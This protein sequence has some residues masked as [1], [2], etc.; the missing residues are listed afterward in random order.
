[1]KESKQEK[2][3]VT[4]CIFMFDL[5]FMRYGYFNIKITI[6]T[7]FLL[8]QQNLQVVVHDIQS[9]IQVLGATQTNQL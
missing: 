4:L 1:V 6:P 9:H 7:C 2:N 5:M 3:S 8:I